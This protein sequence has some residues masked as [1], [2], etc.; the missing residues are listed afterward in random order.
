ML[1]WLT[2]SLLLGLSCYNGF[3]LVKASRRKRTT[4]TLSL[5]SQVVEQSPNLIIIT[6]FRGKI[7]YV[8]PG[9]S[10]MSG[11]STEEAIDHNPRLLKSG[12]MPQ[13]VFKDLWQTI[14]GGETWRGELCNRHKNGAL[15]WNFVSIS[16]IF[17]C[18]GQIIVVTG[19]EGN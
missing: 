5:L 4:E 8:N 19:I 6:D 9:F 12:K 7:K 10:V 11:Y 18:Q 2:L 16:P 13:P 15:F 1:L 17:N 14:T 3:L